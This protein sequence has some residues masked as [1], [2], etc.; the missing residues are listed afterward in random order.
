MEQ[1][2]NWKKFQNWNKLRIE[3]NSKFENV[4]IIQLKKKTEKK[5]D[6]KVETRK[7]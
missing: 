1:L 3:M 2:S 7:K 5:K 4:Q 6:R